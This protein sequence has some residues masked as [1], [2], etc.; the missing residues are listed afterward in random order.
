MVKSSSGKTN[1]RS[2]I[3]MGVTRQGGCDTK[4]KK[5]RFVGRNPVGAARKA[6]NGFCRVKRIR[7][8]CTL[9]VTVQE[10]TVGS[11]KKSFTYK[12]HRKKL[13]TPKVMMEGTDKEYVIEYGVTAK[14]SN[15]LVKC[16]SSA[17]GKTR[18]RMA[19]R[20]SRKGQKL[21][22]KKRRSS[23]K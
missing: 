4:F 22:N 6:F 2:F 5:G 1:M 18:G 12:L 16:K 21:L 20:T 13:K 23:K 11:A 14:S 10:T 7:G 19:K 8:I 17:K 15:L 3:V 9:T